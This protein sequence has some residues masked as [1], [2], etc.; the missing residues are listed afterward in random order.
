MAHSH[1]VADVIVIG[2]GLSGLRC[3]GLVTELGLDV[4]VLEASDGVGG[5]VRTDRV[6]GYR[7]DRGFQVLF[8]GY[9]E[10]RRALDYGALDLRGFA[11]GADVWWDGRMRTVGHPLRDPRSIPSALRSGLG[12]PS[13]AVAAARWLRE[14]RHLQTATT[15]ETTADARLRDLGFSEPARERLLRPLYAGVFLDRDLGV[16]SHLLDQAFMHMAGGRTVVPAR[17]MGAISDQLA[18]RLPADSIHLGAPV[19][20]VGKRTATV[21]GES[22]RQAKLAVVIAGGAADTAALAGLDAPEPRSSSCLWFAAKTAP[23]GRRIVLDGDGTGPVNNVAVMSQV[24]PAYAPPGREVIA[25]SC[26]GLPFAGDDDALADAARAQLDRWFDGAASTWDLLR[27]DRIEWAQH[28]QPPGALGHG[29][30]WLREGVILAGDGTENASIDGA[31]RAGRRA[32][33]LIRA[34]ARA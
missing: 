11:P 25:A 22:R 24:A 9:P 14:A 7:L 32:A 31:L 21:V 33:E 30:S 13:D 18:A 29:A 3:A 1:V 15:P 2:A 23:A 16:S 8:E 12:G 28:A 19:E 10:A 27:I 6:D 5:R 26:V 20:K 17:G 34:A 4:V